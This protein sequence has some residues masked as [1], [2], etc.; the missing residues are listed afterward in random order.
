MSPYLPAA[1]TIRPLPIALA[2]CLA[3]TKA[4]EQERMALLNRHFSRLNIRDQFICRAELLE[5]KA[6]KR[7]QREAIVS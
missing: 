6:A 3:N 7:G 4:G 5:C 2:Q 1:M